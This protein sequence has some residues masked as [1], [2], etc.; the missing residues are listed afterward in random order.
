MTRE[1]EWDDQQRANM[2]AL[3][4]YEADLCDCGF[5]S[6]VADSDPDLV[7]KYR[8]CPVCAGLAKVTRIQASADAALIKQVYG[9]NGAQPADELP[10]DG[11]RLVG[12]ESPPSDPPA[13]T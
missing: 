5:P 13:A 2:L 7:V 3:A 12:F 4:D 11:R 1:A 9:Q 6:E 10:Q 8:E